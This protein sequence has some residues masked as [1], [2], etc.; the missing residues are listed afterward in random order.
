MHTVDYTSNPNQRTPCLLILDASGSMDTVGASGKSRI[1]AL[2]EGI[3]ALEH[4]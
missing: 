1:Q 3:K 2:N 4:P